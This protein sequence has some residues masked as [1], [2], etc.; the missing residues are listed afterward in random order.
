MRSI[1]RVATFGVLLISVGVNLVQF[2]NTKAAQQ[3]YVPGLS[4]TYGFF[5]ADCVN[6]AKGL[7]LHFRNHPNNLA[8][9]NESWSE[10]TGEL[11]G[12]IPQLEQLGIPARVLNTVLQEFLWAKTD[13]P[14]DYR[15]SQGLNHQYQTNFSKA[16]QF[17]ALA[18][19]TLPFWKHANSSQEFARVK[20]AFN[21]LAKKGAFML[22]GG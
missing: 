20:S 5:Q 15:L 2:E 10:A 17:I 9:A 3:R 16:K 21:V 11:R 19:T 1:W 7:T 4:N 13:L 14:P 8:I 6:T 18:S 22:P 12:A